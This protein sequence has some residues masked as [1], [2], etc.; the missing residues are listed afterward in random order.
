MD[1]GSDEAPAAARLLAPFTIGWLTGGLHH[2]SGI[3]AVLAVLGMVLA[4]AWHV[5]RGGA[6][7][8]VLAGGAAGVALGA[9]ASVL[10][11]PPPAADHV[12]RLVGARIVAVEGTIVASERSGSRVTAT[13]R[14]DA[15]RS[16]ARTGTATGLVGVTIAH[17]AAEWPR[18]TRVRLVGTLRRPRS[19]ANPG[20]HDWSGSLRRRGVRATMF[21]WDERRLARLAATT[22]ATDRLRVTLGAWITRRT[23]EPVRGYLTA[24]L[25]GATQSLDRD[26]RAALTRTGLA[27]VVSV[28]GFHVA[29]AAGACVVALRWGLLRV[30][31]LALR[32]DVTTVAASA[33]LVPVAAYAAIA[34]GTVPATRAFLTYAV[35]VAVVLAR[36]P[37]DGVRALALVALA[38]AIRTPDV[39]ADVSFELSFASVLALLAVARRA[40]PSTPADAGAL[41][42]RWRSLVVAPIVTSVAAGAAT[43]PLTAWHF[44]QISL[45]AP[46]AN[47][48]VLPLLGPATLLPGLA[49]LP[50]V[51]VLPNAADALLAVASAAASL[52]LALAVRLAALPGAAVD[53]PMPSLLEVALAYAALALGW[54]RHAGPAPPRAQHAAVAILA[55]V[56]AADVAYWVWERWGNAAVRVTFLSVGQGDAA[57]VELP[58]G[59][60]MVV[61]AGGL[62]GDFD[63]GERVVAPFLRSRKILR[64]DVLVV[65]HPQLDHHG[66][67]AHV[68]ERFRPAEIWSSG[69]RGTSA[70]YARLDAAVSAAG[71]RTVTLARGMTRRLGEVRVEV[72]H[73]ERRNGL[74]VNDASLV[75]RLVHGRTA[76]LFTGDIE[77]VA[78]SELLR[79]GVVLASDVLKVPH[80]GSA[81]SS[82]APWLAAVAPRIAVV[83]SGADNRFGFPAPTVLR[84]LRATGARVWNTAEDGAVHV[85][86]DGRDVRVHAF[87]PAPARMRFEFPKSLW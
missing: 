77:H 56:A 5:R 32:I 41:R 52:G 16:A 79:A 30:G 65:S 36:R 1:R 86:G 81:T 27:H 62:P 17:A 3:G 50:L 20:A 34:G 33:G 4:V 8:I 35:L 72:L 44:Q 69:A 39:A 76:Y 23:T 46:L 43:A 80:H 40:A 38:I 51:A 70:A 75:L 58:R 54:W 57:V 59:P 31:T 29:V 6:T 60:V 13:V 82:T 48:L 84:R 61:D 14:A 63:P 55:I 25:L 87:R 42:R 71:V 83:S 10:A 73:P 68:A 11:Y 12:A 47:L 64:V 15:V 67:L 74:G 22:D 85:I 18:G 2:P 26:T 66:G 78:E 19:V 9:L 53:T 24:V 49:A 21:L 37:L 28:S 7:P 45:I